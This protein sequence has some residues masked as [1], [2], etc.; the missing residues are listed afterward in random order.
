MSCHYSEQQGATIFWLKAVYSA[1]KYSM[2]EVELLAIVE[3]L[4]EFKGITWGRTITVYMDH[5]NPMQD[6][7]G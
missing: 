6:A 2:T 7:L 5:K 4:K 3:T 1:S